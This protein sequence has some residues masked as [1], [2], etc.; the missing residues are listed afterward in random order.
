[1]KP[2]VTIVIP[3]FNGAA[4]LQ[5]NLPSVLAAAYAYGPATP[6][7]VVD[8]GS[9]DESLAVLREHFPQVRVVVHERNKGFAEAVYSGI[10]AA[11][12][13]LIFLLNSDVQP[14]AGCLD[15]LVAYFEE[16]DTF[17]VCPVAR[18]ENGKVDRHSWNRR[19]FRRGSL[20]PV[21]WT[22]EQALEARKQGN[23][24]TLY[25][26]GG[27]MLLRKSMFLALD[28]F[29]PLFKPFYGEDYDLGLR[30]WRRGWRSY[31]EP[32]ASV[33]H[34][35]K[36]SSIKSNTR[37]AYV[38]RIRRRNKYLLEWMHLPVW[39]LWTRTIPLYLWQLLG[40]VLL[41]DRV[42]LGGF[43]MALPRIPAIL[44]MRC[45]LKRAQALSIEQT[46]KIVNGPI[47]GPTA[48]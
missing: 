33:V 15:L 25:A 26:S 9:S 16:L 37:K 3:N 48:Q 1:M 20:K 35:R 21:D 4:L 32:Q 5:R 10:R 7:I 44:K 34:Q 14:D 22:L 13:E 36:G 40:E 31:F 18:D 17:A 2:E 46:L 24:A 23:L 38:K 28:G 39:Q 12:A 29:N 8:D 45:E 19:E 27:S 43:A 11:E 41:L 6:V 42:N 30:A 47:I